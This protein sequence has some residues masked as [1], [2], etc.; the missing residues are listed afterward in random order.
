MFQAVPPR[1]G[2]PRPPLLARSGA[3]LAL[4]AAAS[5]A[6]WLRGPLAPAPPSPAAVPTAASMPAAVAVAA[7]DLLS[8]GVSRPPAFWAV[9]VEEQPRAVA[10]QATDVLAAPSVGAQAL[11]SEGPARVE[12]TAR[13]RGPA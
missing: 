2:L 5:V 10:T 1:R 4:V 8:P 7:P 12:A 11:P 9:T 3:V 13:P 6:V